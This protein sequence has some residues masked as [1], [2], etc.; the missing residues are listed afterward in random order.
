MNVKTESADCQVSTDGSFLRIVTPD[1]LTKPTWPVHQKRG[2]DVYNVPTV[3]RLTPQPKGGSSLLCRH[4][5]GV[6]WLKMADLKPHSISHDK[7]GLKGAFFLVLMV[8]HRN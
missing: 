3:L 1:R 2:D 6:Q 7:A 8:A 4:I 5:N